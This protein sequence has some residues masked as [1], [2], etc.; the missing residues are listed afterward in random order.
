[1]IAITSSDL[2]NALRERSFREDLFHRLN[3]VPLFV[4]ALRER[5]RD[6]A[7]LAQHFLSHFAAVHHRQARAFSKDALHTLESYAFPGNIRELRNLC[8]RCTVSAQSEAIA[9]D[10]LPRHIRDSAGAKKATLAEMERAYIA[11]ILDYTRGKKSKAAAILGISRK[12][13][14]EKRK[15]YKLD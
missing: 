12:N 10:E 2:E 1:M 14:L 6:I 7:P 3:V 5:R 13:L 11:E 8:E 15:R 9:T 4:P